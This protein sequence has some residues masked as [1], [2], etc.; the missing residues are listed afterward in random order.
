[1]PS[2]AAAGSSED[3]GPVSAG[4]S[5]AADLRRRAARRRAVDALFGDV[6]PDITGDETARGDDDG[7]SDRWYVENR[8]PHHG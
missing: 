5:S 2:E 6:L 3:T 4:S 8:P 7:R 1:M